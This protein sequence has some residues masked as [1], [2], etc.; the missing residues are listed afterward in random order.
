MKTKYLS[1][2]LITLLALFTACN[3]TEFSEISPKPLTDA[4]RWKT[5]H[6]ISKL[7]EE[8]ST[9]ESDYP[10]R[11]NSGDKDLFRV[12]TI[13]SG[14]EP[15]IITGRV[16]STDMEGSIYKNLYIQDTQTGEALKISVNVSGVGSVYAV[17]QLLN[18][19]CNGLVIGKYGD[20]YQLGSLYYNDDANPAKKGYEPGRIAFPV[21]K[22]QVQLDG[23]PEPG[24]L[25]IPD[26]TIAQI[27]AAG[28]AVHSKL[29][30]I[31]NANFTGYGEIN[32]DRKL[33]TPQTSFFGLPK[34]TITGVP[35]AREI[36]DGTGRMNIAT[37]EF[38]K[39]ASQPLPATTFKGDILVLVG[40]YWDSVGTPKYPRYG[41]WQ[42]TLRSLNDLGPG[43]EEYLKQINYN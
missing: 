36:T 3:Q 29:V 34:P 42:L 5:T 31:K 23:A 22:A 17:G 21:F 8:F 4:E 28:R 26:M 24:K 30:R 25:I 14:G 7:I 15:V 41:S 12:D 1:I 16:T 13:R 32:F 35:I 27:T 11:P 39:F 43:F 2:I 19:K 38:A 18:I 9:G 10:V 20:V 6:T 40:W 33:L 37:S